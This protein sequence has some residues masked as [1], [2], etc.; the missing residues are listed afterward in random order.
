[1]RSGSRFAPAGLAVL[2]VAGSAA[3]ALAQRYHVQTYTEADGLPSPAIESIAQGPDG[4]L[5][6]ATRSGVV[7]YDG[8]VWRNY[9][10]TDGLPES[11]QS[12][13]VID[14]SGTP[15]SVA[16]RAPV[17]LSSFDG[18]LWVAAQEAPD[19]DRQALT[20]VL[21]NV[22]GSEQE[23]MLVATSSGEVLVL[24]AGT[25][26]TAR[27]GTRV[28][29]A[30]CRNGSV[31][32]ATAN[33]LTVLPL[34]AI[35]AGGPGG[36]AVPF[37]GLPEGEV[38]GLAVDS[39]EDL[40]LVGETW[41]ARLR[42]DGLEMLAD[43]VDLGFMRGYVG[44]AVEPDGAGGIHFG[45]PAVLACFRPGQP[46][47]WLGLSSGL[48]SD[49]VSALV[50]DR[51]GILWVGSLRGLSKVVSRRF[52]TWDSAH[53]LFAD[54]VSA[55]L[56]RRSGEIVLGHNGGVTF[57]GDPMRT[58]LFTDQPTKARILDIAEAEDGTLWLAAAWLGL[59]ELP[60]SGRFVAHAV[61]GENEPIF[62]VARDGRGRLWAGAKYPWLREHGVWK[63]VH[64]PTDEPKVAYVRRL[65]ADRRGDMLVATDGSGAFRVRD[66]G[67]EHWY[68]RDDQSANSTYTVFED[69]GGTVWVGSLAG[70]YRAEGDRL[71][72]SAEPGPRVDRP[73][74]LVFDDRQGNLWFG[75]DHGAL[76]WDGRTLRPFTTHEGLPGLEANRSAGMAD[77]QGVWIGTDRGLSLYREE[78][79]RPRPLGPSVE[80]LG[81]DVNGVL[82]PADSPLELA[83]RDNSLLF[84][85]RAI[86]FVDE[87]RVRFRFR[88]EGFES[89]WVDAMPV[90]QRSVRYP[91]LPP[92]DYRFWLQAVDAEGT[93]SA[94]AT[95]ATVHVRRSLVSHPAVRAV[96]AAAVLGLLF[97]VS[98]FYAVRRQGRVLEKLVRER[99]EELRRTERELAKTQRLE[100]LG[101]LAGGI[102]HDFNNLLQV[103]LGGASLLEVSREVGEKP[104]G[105]AREV[106]IAAKRA[107]ALT[108]QLLTF[109]TG[110]GPRRRPAPLGDVVRDAVGFTLAGSSVRAELDLAT[111]LRLVEIDP[112]Q[113]TRVLDNLLLN[114][115]QA[116][117]AGGAVRVRAANVNEAPALP[118][119]RWVLLEIADEGPGIPAKDLDFVFDPFFSTR[120][121]GTG[122]GLAVAHS[123]IEKHGGRITVESAP[124][125]GATFRIWLPASDVRPEPREA[126]PTPD[127][128]SHDG[129]ILVMDD[130]ASVRASLREMLAHLGYESHGVRDGDEVVAAYDEAMHAG[131]R[132]DAVIM[133]LTVPG[134]AGG[135]AAMS[136]LREVDPLIRAVVVSGYSS[137]PAMERYEDFGFLG[138]LGKPFAADDLARVLDRALAAE[139]AAPPG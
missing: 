20:T 83:S 42:D 95:S 68:S 126:A 28:N 92:G 101:V 132:F 8:A 71:V 110:G 45:N 90:P 99:T 30:A 128:G 121:G 79:D 4:V 119:G 52:A 38:L 2:A 118:D 130:D 29:A 1:M 137:D 116:M 69:A 76:R 61:A 53:G 40:W 114:A 105:L 70:L 67:I 106:R 93:R 112:E 12:E 138:C 134:G 23:A 26:T 18:R 103:I 35:R 39:G 13:V 120:P 139:S 60:A 59:V 5:W 82:H 113:I 77:E 47:E 108:Q 11:H 58:L 85:F 136:R 109:S 9:G 31:Y 63:E 33:G 64:L 46:I 89:E 88:L 62:A 19:T 135:V 131:R 22:P 84:P 57:F 96:V 80:L 107:R 41:I 75:T 74:Y 7:S 102:A 87:A 81:V 111:D 48:I 91:N 133:D 125:A 10:E 15:W 43:D 34:E 21:L 6:I 24:D 124:D 127:A 94:P 14:S 65:V 37:S 122:L 54:E 55:V 98:R 73:V 123:V 104:R 56:K 32:F 78:L 115:R 129:R 51:E 27:A 3:P 25:W 100:S 86:S 17:R 44:A 66:D 117:T 50:Q 16:L 72:R 36:T 97:L 49:G